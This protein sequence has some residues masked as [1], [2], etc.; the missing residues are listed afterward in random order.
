MKILATALTALTFATAAPGTLA[1]T[2]PAKTIKV[3]IPFAAGSGTDAISRPVLAEM[4][5]ILEQPIIV[6][7]RPGGGGI[8]G[9]QAVA[10][11]DPDGYTVLVHS[12]SFTVVPSTYRKLAFNPASDFVGVMPIGSL[13]MALVTSPAK[14]FRDLDDLLAKAR[15]KV[16]SITYA[17]AGTGGATHLGAERFRIA[18]GFQA[19][20][21]PYK[22]SA[23]AI[24]DVIAGQVDYYFSPIGLALQQI[25]SGRLQALAVVSSSRSAALPSTPTT[26]EAG[27]KDSNYDVWV[28]MWAPA[29]TPAPVVERLNR[30]MVEA[31]RTP[32]VTQAFE[33]LVADPM[34]MSPA[35]FADKIRREIEINAMLVKAA[36]I[37]PE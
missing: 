19:V 20:H 9:M 22:G 36:G 15:A 14:G 17:S 2:W 32:A 8:I 25:S 37:Q 4:S 5:R 26:L 18:G 27:L 1:Q 31:I 29:R 34:I 7:N 30:T 10:Q 23:G 3:I 13:P 33:R 16:G 35:E 28:G 6:E 21:V 24:T 12:N 11:A